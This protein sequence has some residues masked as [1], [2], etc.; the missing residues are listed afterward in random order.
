MNWPRGQGQ[1]TWSDRHSLASASEQLKV[2]TLVISSWSGPGWSQKSNFKS[3]Q[4]KEDKSSQLRIRIQRYQ[5]NQ[6]HP[7]VLDSKLAFNYPTWLCPTWPGS[8]RHDL[9]LPDTTRPGSARPGSARP[10]SSRLALLGQQRYSTWQRCS[11]WRDLMI[12]LWRYSTWRDLMIL[13]V[14][15]WLTTWQWSCSTWPDHDLMRKTFLQCQ[16]K[17]T[18]KTNPVLEILICIY[19]FSLL[20]FIMNS[21]DFW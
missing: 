14:S 5:G 13:E 12:W 10:G 2:V 11:T 6:G 9:A 15:T 1:R 3:G 4:E 17:R 20:C 19:I 21:L 16:I 18:R 8:A 7:S